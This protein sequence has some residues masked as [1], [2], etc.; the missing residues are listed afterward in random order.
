MDT[1]IHSPGSGTHDRYGG[2][3]IMISTRLAKAEDIQFYAPHPAWLLHV[4]VPHGN[5]HIDILNWYQ[6][7]IYQQDGTFDRRQ[8]L[9]TQLQ[10]T[11]SHLPRRNLLLLGGD[12]NCPC[13]P[14]GSACGTAVV[15][16]NPMHS[17]TF[18]T[19]NKLTCLAVPPPHSAQHMLV[20]TS[21]RT[22]GNFRLW[23]G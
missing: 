17:L 18:R 6:Y 11:I 20:E 12:F 10:K 4:R 9:L 22:A 23:G 16:H 1:R 2:L 14:H 15:P 21:R 7:A 13:E 3:L 5:T 8:K 19:T